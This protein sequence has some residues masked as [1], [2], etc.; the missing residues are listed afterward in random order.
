MNRE[1]LTELIDDGQRRRL[2][3][4]ELVEEILALAEADATWAKALSHPLRGAIL[5]SM[6]RDGSLSPVAAARELDQT[7]GTT[8]YHFRQL[9]KLGYIEVCAEVQRRGAT[10]HVYR[11][12]EP[13]ARWS[14]RRR[15]AA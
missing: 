5:Q 4:D 7:V 15:T 11:L 2:S 13:V 3:T 1:Q 8:A 12:T 14:P 9:H 10:E 6:R